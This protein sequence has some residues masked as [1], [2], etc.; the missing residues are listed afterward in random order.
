MQKNLPAL[1]IFIYFSLSGCN[2]SSIEVK[3]LF[4]ENVSNPAGI[5][6]VTPRFSWIL[7]STKRSQVQTAYHILIASTAE[8]LNRNMGDVWDSKKTES[9]QSVLINYDGKE[10]IAATRYYWKVKIWNQEGDNSGWSKTG[11]FQTGLLK[12]DDWENAKWIGYHQLP[13]SMRVVPGLPSDDKRLGNKAIQRAVVPLFRKEIELHKEIKEASLFISG[14]GQYEASLN[15]MKI[16][17]GFL[18]PGWT[19]YDKSVF[20]NCYDV[21]SF[22][23]QGKNTIGVIVGNGFYYVNRERYRKLVV[24]Y[25]EPALIGQL[26]VV[27][28]DGS[29]DVY[30]TNE[31]WKCSPSPIT[32]SSIYGGEDY[33]ATLELDN[34]N[35]VVFDD[36]GWQNALTVKGPSGNLIAET[37]IL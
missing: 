15:G 12:P 32:Y 23:Q 5:S 1:L 36:S 34:W 30:V 14:L 13:D 2:Q 4:C 7:Q 18:T 9:D 37:I 35:K 29:D 6:S 17:S 20:Y 25:G 31:T 24:A 26:R 11:T 21:T 10:L 19:N 16:G 33:N 8:I 28:T 3:D 27:Y 22:L